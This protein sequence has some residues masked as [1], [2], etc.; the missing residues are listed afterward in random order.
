METFCLIDR[1]CPHAYSNTTTAL[2]IHIHYKIGSSEVILCLDECHKK[3]KFYSRT[4]LVILDGGGLTC[5]CEAHL[6]HYMKLFITK[7]LP[8]LGHRRWLNYFYQELVPCACTMH[9]CEKVVYRNNINSKKLRL[10]NM[11]Q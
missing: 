3:L 10:T 11:N 6:P 2:P 9:G 7:S 1:Y 8:D 5:V 4:E